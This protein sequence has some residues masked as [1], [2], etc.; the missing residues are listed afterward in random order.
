MR[1][2]SKIFLILLLSIIGVTSVN[3][4]PIVEERTEE[5]LKVNKK[6]IEITS[7]NKEN[8]LNTPSVNASEKIYD[9]S[10]VLTDE[11]EEN[12]YNK[13]INFISKTKID[14]VIV[15]I[16]KT[17]SDY[18]IEEFAD[19]FFDYND[20]GMNMSDTSY[21]GILVVRNTNDYNRYYYISTGGMGQVYFPKDRVNDILD[22]MYNGMHNDLYYEGFNSFIDSSYQNYLLGIPSK[23][24]GATVDK[25]GDLYDSN[26]KLVS[27][28]TG[29]YRLPYGIALIIAS[30]VTLITMIILIS[31]NRMIEKATKAKEY[32]DKNSV[33]YTKKEDV[34]LHTHT[35]S[36]KITSSSGSG[37]GGSHHSSSGFSHGGGGRHC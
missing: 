27:Y 6:E 11:E 33:N 23:Y 36:Y 8:I 17:W 22:D 30:I 35:T 21:D 9:F 13:V 31:K 24:E 4:L 20:F 32:L 15:T 19:D 25:K 5:N 12:L 10:D 18:Q 14:M 16:N 2:L 28:E 34:F 3:A 26:G 7:I 37:G 29:V 1:K